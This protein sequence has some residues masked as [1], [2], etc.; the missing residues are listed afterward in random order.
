MAR[1]WFIYL[2][3]HGWAAFDAKYRKSA[4][5]ADSDNGIA[6]VPSGGKTNLTVGEYLAA[7]RTESDLKHKTIADYEGCLGLIVSEVLAMGKGNRRRQ[8]DRYMGGHKAW[9]ADVDAMPLDSVTPERVRAWKKDYVNRA[10][11]DE[12]ARRRLVVNVNSY[13]RRARALFSKRKVL[14]KLRSVQLPAILPFDGVQLERRTD[15]KFMD[16]VRVL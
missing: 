4:E 16:A 2:S 8:K 1:D 9:M 11:R 15:Q 14:D 13:V 6:V 7:V 3:A 12:L 5:R 10:G